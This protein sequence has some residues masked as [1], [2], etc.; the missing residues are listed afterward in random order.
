MKFDL[1]KFKKDLIGTGNA[2]VIDFIW[3]NKDVL[4]EDAIGIGIIHRLKNNRNGHPT[5]FRQLIKFLNK[6]KA[7]TIIKDRIIINDNFM[8]RNQVN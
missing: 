2:E 5:Q 7:I 3:L 8:P 4:Y 6:I 1:E